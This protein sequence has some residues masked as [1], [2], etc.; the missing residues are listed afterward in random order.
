MAI[1]KKQWK[2]RVQK[3]NKWDRKRF[4]LKNKKERKKLNSETKKPAM[5]R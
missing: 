2:K 5:G 1:N 4:D 3:L